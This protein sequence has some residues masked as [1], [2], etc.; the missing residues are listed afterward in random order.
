MQRTHSPGTGTAGSRLLLLLVAMLLCGLAQLRAQQSSELPDSPTAQNAASVTGIVTD[1]DGAAITGA[2]ITL[3]HPDEPALATQK[4]VSAADGGFALNNIAPGAFAITI[5]ANGFSAETISGT[6]APGQQDEL[7]TIALRG[8]VNIGVNVSSNPHEMAEIE[9]RNE[10]KQRVAGIIPNYYIVYGTNVAPL[11]TKQKYRLAWRTAIDPT[12]FLGAGAVAG[13]MQARNTFPTYGQ[14][15][16]GYSKRFAAAYGNG[17]TATF[18]SNAVF[19]SLFKQDPRYFYKGTGSVRSRAG[20]AIANAVI[21]KGDNGHWQP[22]YSG[23]LGSLAAGGISNLYYPPADRNGA[24]ITFENALFGIAGGAV[25]NLFEEFLLKKF[26]THS[27]A[28]T[29]P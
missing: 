6:L 21:C 13:I 25:S 22:D 15:A 14:G 5:T 12:S 9:V 2:S 29:H 26:T 27:H 10:E 4:T 24:K 11:D 20:Y 17:F 1:T 3:S 7:H 28:Q 16:A 18:L 8:S 19:A 23:I